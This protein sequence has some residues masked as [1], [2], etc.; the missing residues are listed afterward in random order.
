MGYSSNFRGTSSKA[1]SRGVASGYQSGSISDIAA[2]AP[3]SVNGAGMISPTDVSS[4]ASATSFVGLANALISSSAN[5][6]VT[7]IGRLEGLTLAGFSLGDAVYVG[8]NGT[9]TNI[10]PNI[11]INS[12]TTGDFV[13]F[14]GLVVKNEF[15]P[16][17]KDI[18]LMPEMI[19]QI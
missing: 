17:K 3:V 5:G 15:D 2:G 16:A 12:F 7:T 9:L 6:Q 8:K 4:E 10:K 18:L 13:I 1:P 14:V 11:G 19:G